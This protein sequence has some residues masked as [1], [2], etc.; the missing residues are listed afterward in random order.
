L[1][2]TIVSDEDYYEALRAWCQS[3]Y[4]WIFPVRS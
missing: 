2:Y 1:G 3:R 4:D